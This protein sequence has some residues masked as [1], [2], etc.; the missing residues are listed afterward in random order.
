[1]GALLACASAKALFSPALGFSAV[2]A[3]MGTH[4]LA[5]LTQSGTD[6]PSLPFRG[7]GNVTQQP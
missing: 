1:M 7:R 6:V 3:G 4:A 5:S 2:A